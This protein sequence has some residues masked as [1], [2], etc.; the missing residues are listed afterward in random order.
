[1]PRPPLVLKL[2]VK[3]AL[4][5][6]GLTGGALALH[7]LP[8]G[9]ILKSHAHA[10]A[11][12]ADAAMVVGLGALACAVGMPRQIVAFAAGY[13]WGVAEG[14]A[15]AL[16]AQVVG[17]AADFFWARLIARDFVQSRLRGRALRLDRLL[18]TKPF[19][20]AL[21][22]RLMPVGNNLLLN[23]LAGVSAVPLR[24]FI[25]GSAVGFV[26]QT[27]IFALL[28]SGSRIAR[29]TQIEIGVGLFAA[30]TTI[31]IMLLRRGRHR[32]STGPALAE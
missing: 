16:L 9:A 4:L 29:G 12:L 22:L 11:S 31:G 2:I 25:M 14:G 24:G 28:G 21:T 8:F 15:L 20:T 5:L 1:M 10:H 23:L 17:C 18:T 27:V 30:S 7:M 19:I 32:A 26:P 6:L 13:A 3:P